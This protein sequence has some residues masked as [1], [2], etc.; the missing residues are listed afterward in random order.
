MLSALQSIAFSL[1]GPLGGKSKQDSFFEACQQAD[2]ETLQGLLASQ[3][4][5]VDD[6]NPW[7]FDWT[8]LHYAA[9]ADDPGLVGFLMQ[10]G[11][12][13]TIRAADGRTPLQW[14]RDT[15]RRQAV[16]V[17]EAYG[18]AG[19]WSVAEAEAVLRDTLPSTVL[20]NK[21][22]GMATAAVR[23]VVQFLEPLGGV[24]GNSSSG[25]SAFTDVAELTAELTSAARLSVDAVS[26]TATAAGAQAATFVSQRLL[27]RGAEQGALD[28]DLMDVLPEIHAFGR[29]DGALPGKD[30]CNAARETVAS[31][32]C[33]ALPDGR[34][35]RV[36]S[37]STLSVAPSTVTQEDYDADFEFLEV[38]EA[39]RPVSV[40]GDAAAT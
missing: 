10:Y 27:S 34:H 28:G 2:Y 31:P 18:E 36:Q 14:A 17:L 12:D 30:K 37:F 21:A 8:G 29:L 33:P 39:T 24:D 32:L 22:N 23:A 9:E 6:Q 1:T 40:E 13:P 15:G 26:A 38:L 3:D 7:H 19:A 16:T 35:S 20:R 4:V 25:R 5:G 11:A